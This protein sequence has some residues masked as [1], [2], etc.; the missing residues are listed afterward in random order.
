MGS[1]AMRIYGRVSSLF[2]ATF[3]FATFMATTSATTSSIDSSTAV[4]IRVDQSGRG[5]FKKIQDAIDAVPSN[6]SELVFIWV[7]PGTYRFASCVPCWLY[8][9]IH[10][11]SGFNDFELTCSCI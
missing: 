9:L 4:L 6:N 2:V 8:L 3:V 7:K 11:L 5:D 1:A 10:Y